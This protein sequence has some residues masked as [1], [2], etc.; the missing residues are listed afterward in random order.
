MF[1]AL[2]AAL[3]PTPFDIVRHGLGQLAVTSIQLM[4]HYANDYFDYEADVANLTP[5]RWSGG[6]RVLVEKTLPRRA[7]LIAALVLAATGLTFSVVLGIRHE[8][9]PLLLPLFVA[10]LV[11]AWEYSAPPLRLC[12]T[13][14]GELDT[15]LVVTALVPFAGFYVQTGSLEGA[16]P[17]VLAA[18]PLCAL[19]LAMLLAIELPDA[20]GDVKTG[21]RTLVVRLG[22][23]RAARLY[24]LVTA[25]AYLA[26]PLLV[27][28]GLPARV[29]AAAALP[30]P[31]ALW[32]IV[33]MLRGDGRVRAQWETITFWAVG[34]LVATSACELAAA[35]LSRAAPDLGR[36]SV[37]IERLRD[38]DASFVVDSQHA[39]HA[40]IDIGRH[41]A[42][43]PEEA[44]VLRDR[45][46]AT[47]P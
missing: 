28:F 45:D 29:A 32:R 23:A 5:T 20:E 34:L 35:G 8:S 40:V 6:S 42:I 7:A 17:I 26:L 1:Y 39:T 11:L 44:T 33:R 19:Q 30:A 14:F 47:R 22:A 10:M 21:K 4:T 2:G 24:A 13:G 18:L 37:G 41:P 27:L 9:G 15:M 31:V 12:A 3:A 46:L 36:M 43:D 38:R 25:L 16:R